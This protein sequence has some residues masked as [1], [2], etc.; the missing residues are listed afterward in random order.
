[1]RF[2]TAILVAALV[3]T[4]CNRTVETYIPLV[5]TFEV[6]GN[7][8]RKQ[9][10][11]PGK[12][13]SGLNSSLAF[14]VSG[15]IEEVLVEPGE[16]IKKG[17]PVAV[18]DK[19]D[20]RT[21]LN[22]TEAEYSQV[23]AEVERVM[24][25]YRDD[26]VTANDYDKARY[27]LTQMEQKL[28]HHRSQLADCTLKAPFDGC[29]D[30]INFHKGET[31]MSG[32]P[33][34]SMFGAGESE[35]VVNMSAS[36]YQRRNN[37]ESITATFAA[38]EGKEYPLVIKNISR[39]ANANQLYEMQL[40]LENDDPEI[41]PGMTAMVTVRFKETENKDK[42]RIPS[43]AIFRKE[44]MDCVFCYSDSTE[45]ISTR[46]VTIETIENNGYALVSGLDKGEI[47]VSAGVHKLLDGQKVRRAMPASKT[48]P[49]GL[50]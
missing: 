16:S 31:V 41:T 39:K 18:L 27:G 35:I 8:D 17:Q 28:A 21:Q 11:Y 50:L 42:Y 15:T 40:K 30:E 49:G 19:R 24:A 32:V 22:A 1:M 3:L 6:K 23:K 12:S 48:N 25:M 29:V 7:D 33:I 43:N 20:Y 45:C 44:E 4:S 9:A 36:D 13:T 47:I 2:Q 46:T 14:K 5:Q 37:I 38:L 10:T 26:A 34:L